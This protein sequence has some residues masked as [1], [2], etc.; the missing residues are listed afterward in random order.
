MLLIILII[1]VEFVLLSYFF[2]KKLNLETCHF[3]WSLLFFFL[4]LRFCGAN[5]Y[6]KWFYTINYTESWD[7]IYFLFF[8]I[9][10]VYSICPGGSSIV[11]KGTA[12]GNQRTC[13][14][15]PTMH[16]SRSGCPRS[17]PRQNGE[18]NNS[19]QRLQLCHWR[20]GFG[21]LQCLSLHDFWLNHGLIF[22]CWIIIYAWISEDIFQ[23]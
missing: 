22:M 12:F 14:R 17:S 15:N 16:P 2:I 21:K 11:R 5:I 6:F 10:E 1:F 20:S 4:P 7:L 23:V 9:N 18:K 13:A 19:C 3:F 8:W